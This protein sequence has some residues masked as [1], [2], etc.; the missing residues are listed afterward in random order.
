MSNINFEISEIAYKRMAMFCLR[1]D[2]PKAFF[3]R[4]I[5]ERAAMQRETK[6]LAL[7]KWLREKGKIG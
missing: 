3:Y 4:A 1:H 6:D 7:K 2:I 5:I